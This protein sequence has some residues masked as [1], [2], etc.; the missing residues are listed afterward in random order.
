MMGWETDLQ[1]RSHWFNSWLGC[2]S[3][4]TLGRLFTPVFSIECFTLL[5]TDS[6][7]ADEDKDFKDRCCQPTVL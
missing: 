3:V 4:T 2:E 6:A 1:V 7:V 5:T